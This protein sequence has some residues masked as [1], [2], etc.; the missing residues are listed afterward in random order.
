[1]SEREYRDIAAG[2][3]LFGGVQ[4]FQIVVN[5]LRGKFIAVLLGPAGMGVSALL[6]ATMNMINQTAS[7]GLNLGAVRDISMASHEGDAGRL[8]RVAKVFRRLVFATALLGAAGA[9][10][11]AGLWSRLAFGDAAYRWAFVLLGAMSFFTLLGWGET[12]L[13]QGTRKLRALALTS[14]IGAGVGLVVGVPMYWMWG[15]AGIAPAMVALALATWLSNRLFA[16]SVGLVRGVRVTAAETGRHGRGMIALG[17]A[18]TVTSMLGVLSNWLI[19]W[20]IRTAG[21]LSDVGLYQAATAITTGYIGFVFSAMAMDY[22]PRLAAVSDDADAVR[23]SVNRQGEM[24]VLVAAPIIVALLA[25]A[26]LVVRVLLSGEFAAAVPL[27]RWMGLGLLFK[28]AS[29]ALGYISFCKGDRR[30]FFW[31]EGVAGNGLV[32][33]CAAAGYLLWGLDG[34]GVAALATYAIYFALVSV[35]ARSRY[36]F[37]FEGGFVRLLALLGGLCVVA[38]VLTLAIPGHLWSGLAA[39]LVLAATCVV[40]WRELDKRINLREVIRQRFSHP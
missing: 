17:V 27:V 15:T 25:T 21:G 32:A 14:L 7:L 22:F 38:F 37:R 9:A 20:F 4:V 5:I 34:L 11:G 19:A 10:A 35:V 2:T 36:G 16:R 26:P 18:M 30:T 39:G 8:S 24:V 40:C 3:A 29:F 23:R 13:L 33:G 1:M 12:A 28:T 6:T 31:L